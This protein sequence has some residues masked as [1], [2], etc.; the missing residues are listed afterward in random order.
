[1]SHNRRGEQWAGRTGGGGVGRRR[2][3]NGR[4]QPTVNLSAFF[5]LTKAGIANM[6]AALAQLLAPRG[7][8]A[9]SVAPHRTR[10]S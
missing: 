6:T 3:G 5:Y 1:M 4:P 7:I 8:R 10:E 2:P 9:K